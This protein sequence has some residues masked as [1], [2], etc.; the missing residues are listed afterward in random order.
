M[1]AEHGTARAL[2]FKVRHPLK[3]KRTTGMPAT[4]YE[5]CQSGA[6][7]GSE[8]RNGPLYARA[9]RRQVCQT[10]H[11]GFGVDVSSRKVVPGSRLS[12][13]KLLPG[14]LMF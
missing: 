3:K 6:S 13:G 7:Q 12:A 4:L 8:G 1:R 5:V 9:S 14:V 2:A 10:Q 11:G